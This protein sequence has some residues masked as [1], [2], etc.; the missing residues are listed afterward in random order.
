MASGETRNGRSCIPPGCHL[1][2][3]VD[4]AGFVVAVPL[5]KPPAVNV[6]E[7]RALPPHVGGRGCPHMQLQAVPACTGWS[8]GGQ[9]GKWSA[10]RCSIQRGPAVTSGACGMLRR[11]ITYVGLYTI[12]SV[13]LSSSFD[14]VWFLQKHSASDGQVMFTG[15]D[16][17]KQVGPAGS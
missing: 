3:P 6:D 10:L 11:A 2:A 5:L 4:P 17:F 14:H 8:A 12:P 1:L 9:H 7:R 16:P 15:F 13:L